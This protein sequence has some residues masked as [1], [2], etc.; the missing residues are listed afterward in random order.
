MSARTWHTQEGIFALGPNRWRGVCQ[1]RKVGGGGV[2]CSRPESQP[3]RMDGA[4]GGALI[5]AAAVWLEVM[6]KR[7]RAQGCLQD[8]GAGQAAVG[9][10]GLKQVVSESSAGGILRLG[11][12][13]GCGGWE[14]CEGRL[15][16]GKH[17][18]GSPLVTGKMSPLGGAQDGRPKPTASRREKS[19]L[20]F[21]SP[22]WVCTS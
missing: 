4:A 19:V 8:L 16:L 11:T 22:W 17:H 5:R 9:G 15:I 6:L 7:A 2:R 14:G 10:R 12:L 18:C 21:E 3:G 20:P 13:K 1:G